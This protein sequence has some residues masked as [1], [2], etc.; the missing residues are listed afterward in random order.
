MVHR[1]EYL[2]ISLL[3][4]F[5]SV[6]PA[7]AIRRIARVVGFTL[8]RVIRYRQAVA[9][10]NIRRAFPELTAA[11]HARIASESY[12]SVA[13]TLFE[14]VLF[15]RY[16]ERQVRGLCRI[17]NPSLLEQ[18]LAEGRGAILLTAHYGSWE[19]FAQAAGLAAG[20]EGRLL[21]KVQSNGHMARKVDRWRTR[22]GLQTLS[23]SSGLRDVVKTL[24]NGGWVVIAA[25]QAAPK[26][27]VPVRFFGRPVPTYQGPASFA[28]QTGAAILL[29]VAHRLENGSYDLTFHRITHEDLDPSDDAS[30]RI[31]TERHVQATEQIIRADPGQWMW[32]HKR[33]KHVDQLTP[34]V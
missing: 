13:I 23:S 31:L 15:G 34:S 19:V 8:F 24:R 18:T 11:E 28:L 2:L 33:W 29:G 27:S 30:V 32:M 16:D 5:L 6:L 26:E 17:T 14:F 12:Q 7:D 4:A 10:N 22:F 25:D 21:M 3:L 1:L 9:M 20:R